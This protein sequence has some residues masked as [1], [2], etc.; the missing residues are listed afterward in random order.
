MFEFAKNLL[1]A[2]N[3]VNKSEKSAFS[4]AMLKIDLLILRTC[5][6]D[7]DIQMN[8]IEDVV[9]CTRRTYVNKQALSLLI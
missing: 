9:S 8:L 2:V 1:S 4:M 6:Q 3:A 7:Q 5:P